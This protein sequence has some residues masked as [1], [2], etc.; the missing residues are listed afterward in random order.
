MKIIITGGTGFIG[1]ALSRVLVS[2][3][4]EVIALTRSVRPSDIAGVRNVVWDGCT[5]GGWAEFAEGAKAIVNLAGENIAA[6]RW[7][8]RR[9]ES[10]EKSRLDAGKAVCEAVSRVK[11]RPEVVV[12]GS[13][14]GFYGSCG[15]QPV[16]ENSPQGD[17]FLAGVAGRWEKSTAKVE[18]LGVR[19]VVIRTGMVL[20]HGGALAKMLPPFNAG[21][22]AFLGSGHQGV[23]WI[24]L[25]DEV[26]AIVFLIENQG[27]HGV[28]NLSSF[29]PITSNK[30]NTILGEVLNRK[31][32]FRMP[33]FALKL[34]LGQMAE[35]VLLG[36]QFVL[37]QRLISEG[38]S[39]ENPELADALA[40]ILD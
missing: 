6:G 37:P 30:F 29:N 14:V 19:R 23:S 21:L 18:D 35:E 8:A 31:I 32:F 36:G 4:Y 25:N 40:D 7:T 28:Y 16:D 33:A 17:S 24:H 39:F 20:G 27:C 26:R 3:G 11:V 9:K 38:F 10:I 1:K 34:A 15:P 5:S 22:G 12:Q 13:A 2:K